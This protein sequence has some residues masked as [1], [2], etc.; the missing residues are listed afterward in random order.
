MENPITLNLYGVGSGRGGNDGK[1]QGD[2][3]IGGGSGKAGKTGILTGARRGGAGR[4][5][6]G[7][8]I[9]F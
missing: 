5:G 1:G 9:W 3:E 4:G 7:V 2:M 6:A 8:V